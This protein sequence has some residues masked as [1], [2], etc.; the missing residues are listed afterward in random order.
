MIVRHQLE[1]PFGVSSLDRWHREK[2]QKI[3]IKMDAYF[4]W[5]PIS[6]NIVIANMFLVMIEERAFFSWSTSILVFEHLDRLY[7][8]FSENS[9]TLLI[10]EVIKNK[11]AGNRNESWSTFGF[12]MKFPR[13]NKTV[14][15]YRRWDI[16]T[17]LGCVKVLSTQ[18]FQVF[19]NNPLLQKLCWGR[20]KPVC[21]N[22]SFLCRILARA[23]PL[24][25]LFLRRTPGFT[26]KTLVNCILRGFNLQEMDK[27]SRLG[28]GLTRVETLL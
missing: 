13:W 16:P 19:L 26:S 12:H 25:L 21:K 22:K 27:E 15:F 1:M 7:K 10:S 28:D 14:V 9:I 2:L 20:E 24:E 23:A 17:K 5:S 3:Q 11:R 4:C 18:K 8:T 6:F